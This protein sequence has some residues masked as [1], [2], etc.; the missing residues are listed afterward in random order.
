MK[1]KKLRLDKA[2]IRHLTDVSLQQVAGGW[3]NQS[4]QS[5]APSCTLTTW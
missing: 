3:T 4:G 2:T 5:Y 1:N